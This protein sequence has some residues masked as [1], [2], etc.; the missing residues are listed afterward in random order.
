MKS[1]GSFKATTASNKRRSS[2]PITT[3]TTKSQLTSFQTK[4][5][6]VE[7]TKLSMALRMDIK[8]SENEMKQLVIDRGCDPI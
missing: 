2:Q 1:K 7:P 4:V 3:K 6:K 8:V 5:S